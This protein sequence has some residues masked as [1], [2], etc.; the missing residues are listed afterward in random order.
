M[1]IETISRKSEQ[2]QSKGTIVLLHGVCFGAWYWEDNFLPWF[3]NQGYDVIAISYRN[4]GKSESKGSIKWRRVKEYLRDI[5]QVVTTI[6]GDIYIIGHSMGG[7]LTQHYLQKYP[8]L[9]IKKAVLL[10]TVPASGIT[11]ATWQ[12]IKTYPLQFIHAL[13]TFS[14]MPVFRKHTRTKHLMFSSSNKIEALAPIINRMQDESFLAY[15][16]MLLLNRPATRKIDIPLLFIAAANDFLI[17]PAA[18][19]RNAQQLRGN[20]LVLD[21]AH[22]INLEAGW[23]NTSQ[24]IAGFFEQ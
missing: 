13:C 12:I 3:S 20:F 17:H 5:H 9:Q 10:C 1:Y 23:E 7:F 15:L 11:G 2:H 4:H 8:N 18:I 24:Q 22:N 16:D 21:G 14:F 6:K 19:E